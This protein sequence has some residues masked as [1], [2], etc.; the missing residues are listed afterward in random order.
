MKQKELE[1]RKKRVEEFAKLTRQEADFKKSKPPAHV[2][3]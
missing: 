1:E 3:Q 2:E